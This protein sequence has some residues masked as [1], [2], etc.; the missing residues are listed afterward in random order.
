MAPCRVISNF[1]IYIFPHIDF[2]RFVGIDVFYVYL[3]NLHHLSKLLLFIDNSYKCLNSKN[4]LI[5]SK[6]VYVRLQTLP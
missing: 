1:K 6:T 2:L 4:S 3:Y 5:V